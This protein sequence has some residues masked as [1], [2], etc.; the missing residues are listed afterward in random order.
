MV[1]GYFKV[2]SN[3][4]TPFLQGKCEKVRK[5][6]FRITFKRAIWFRGGK[7]T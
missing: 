6:E 3:S 4:F 2:I 1:K 5:F 7:R